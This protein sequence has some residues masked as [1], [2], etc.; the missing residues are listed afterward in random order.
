MWNLGD[1]FLRSSASR[2]AASISTGLVGG[3][4]SS[5]ARRAAISRIIANWIMASAW[6]VS[7]FQPG[8]CAGQAVEWASPDRDRAAA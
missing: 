8:V 2:R 6:A 7:L 1:Q 5:P 3:A 4:S